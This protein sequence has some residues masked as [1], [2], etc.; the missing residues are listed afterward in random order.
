M[1]TPESTTMTTRERLLRTTALVLAERGYGRT[2]LGEVAAR[3]GLR[4]PAVYHYFDSREDLVAEV[5]RAGQQR[6]HEHVAAAIA[7]V[8]GVREQVGAAVEAHLRIELDLSAFAR[9]VTRNAGHVPPVVRLALKQQSAAYHDTWRRLLTR[10]REEG[11]LRPD[12]ELTVARMLVVGALN[13]AVEWWPV[14]GSLSAMVETTRSF[15]DHAL[16]GSVDR[17]VRAAPTRDPLTT[18]A[19]QK[20]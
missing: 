9:A 1:T 12:L 15:V 13:W 14:D 6:V 2:R 17:E 7:D 18:T 8:S 16:F 5:M 4:P 20:P 3:A 19:D 11:L 10:A